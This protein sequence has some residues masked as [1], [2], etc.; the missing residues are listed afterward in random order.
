LTRSLITTA[1]LAQARWLLLM[2]A[3]LAPGKV[4]AEAPW[5]YFDWQPPLSAGCPPRA[6]LEQDVEQ[7][8]DRSVFTRSPAAW[9]TVRGAV[10][11]EGEEV[12]VRLS[13]RSRQGKLLGTRELTARG[14]AALRNS[15]GLVLTLLVERDAGPPEPPARLALG[16]WAGLM[17]NVWPRTAVG[18]GPTL[19]LSLP[20]FGELR[21]DAAYW[22]PLSVRTEA[23]K[24]ARLSA[25]SLGPRVCPRLAG[26]ADS[27]LDLRVCGGVQLGVMF[28]EQTAPTESGLH[29]RLL[30]QA[31]VELRAALRL[32]A[33]ALE[34]AAGPLVVL[35]RTQLYAAQADGTRVFLYGMPLLGVFV[36]FGLII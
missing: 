11:L 29:V 19:A 32:R 20:S 1:V 12:R 18:L 10:E 30:A 5:V 6:V 35:S 27:L 3:V 15:L 14:C 9:M 31:L 4:R 36:A 25:V 28:V 8:L 26:T 13:A 22:L 16:A 23:G 17:P 33:V 7:A 34:L 24:R 2:A 21:A